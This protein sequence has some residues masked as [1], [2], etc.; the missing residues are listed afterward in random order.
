MASSL[1]T[2]RAWR[3]CHDFKLESKSHHRRTDCGEFC[4]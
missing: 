3:I 2:H 1:Y 4:N